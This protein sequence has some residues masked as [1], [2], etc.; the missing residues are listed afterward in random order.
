VRGVLIE[1]RRFKALLRGDE[2]ELARATLE[3]ETRWVAAC[4]AATAAACALYGGTFGLWRSELQ[5]LYTAVK[6]PLV[7]FLTCGGNAMLNGCLALALGT[8][9]GFR[10]SM[11]AILLSFTVMGLVLA[12][13]APIMLFLWWN[14]PPIDAADRAQAQ[15]GQSI[16]LLAHVAVIGFA[17]VVGNCRLW[18]TLRRITGDSRKAYT[19]LFSW[20]A[21]NL[22]LGSQISWILRPWIGSPGQEAPFFS[23]EPMHGN[24][25]EAVWSA[26][27]VLISK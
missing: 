9:I 20:L 2:E 14:T 1:R 12:S 16:T 23:P 22:L 6:F 10:Q 15:I 18:Q 13:F 24:F 11:M 8:G 3:P 5:A 26:L 17:G 21:G 19:V 27:H 25:F 4:L 7:I